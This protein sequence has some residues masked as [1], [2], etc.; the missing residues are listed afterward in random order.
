MFSIIKFLSGFNIFNGEKRGKLLFYFV[1]IAIS[2]AIFYKAF[3]I[4]TSKTVIQHQ[5]IEKQIVNVPEKQ[6]AVGAGINIWKFYLR[7]GIK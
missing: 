1:L 6:D 2:L 7:A 4:P 3:V 5:T